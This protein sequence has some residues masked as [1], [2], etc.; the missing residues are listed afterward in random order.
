MSMI[1]VL[2][3]TWPSDEVTLSSSGAV[4]VTS[5]D[6]STT[7]GCSVTGSRTVWSTASWTVVNCWVL[8]PFALTVTE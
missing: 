4:A 3:I 8:K 5:T 7:P 1:F 2:S 6:C